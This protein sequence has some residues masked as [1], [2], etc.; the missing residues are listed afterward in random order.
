MDLRTP[1][2]K[3]IV[4]VK[5]TFRKTLS[6]LRENKSL[7]IGM[8][9]LGIIVFMSLFADLIAPYGY[10]DRAGGRYDPPNQDHIFGT[11]LLGYDVFSRIIYGSQVALIIAFS[12][13]ILALSVGVPLGIISGYFGGK[14]DR[15]FTLIAD[16]FSITCNNFSNIF[17]RFWY[18]E[19]CSR[20]LC[21]CISSLYSYIFPCCTW[22]SITN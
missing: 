13:T 16:S 19:G 2:K 7:T 8:V 12:G 6:F 5:R 20:G 14:I 21:S 4:D 15:L 17:K 18:F 9:I 11:T 3:S 10:A 1:D 22:A